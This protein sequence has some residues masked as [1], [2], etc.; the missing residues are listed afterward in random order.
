MPFRGL[1]V[2]M[3]SPEHRPLITGFPGKL[4]TDG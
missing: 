2:S 3:G 1:F 4:Q